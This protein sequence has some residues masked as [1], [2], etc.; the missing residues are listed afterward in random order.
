[1]RIMQ[2]QI[3][4]SARDPEYATGMAVDAIGVFLWHQF[5]VNRVP[6]LDVRLLVRRALNEAVGPAPPIDVGSERCLREH[7]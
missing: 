3:G 2:L 7:P 1:M 4:S 6:W 5:P